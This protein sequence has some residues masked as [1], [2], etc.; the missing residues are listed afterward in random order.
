MSNEKTD[1]V[2]RFERMKDASGETLKKLGDA[3]Q[4]EEE[5]AAAMRGAAQSVEWKV[6]GHARLKAEADALREKAEA[7]AFGARF[8]RLVLAAMKRGSTNVVDMLGAAM[9]AAGVGSVNRYTG[10]VSGPCTVNCSDPRGIHAV[11]GVMGGTAN[12]HDLTGINTVVRGEPTVHEFRRGNATIRVKEPPDPVLCTCYQHSEP[13]IHVQAD[14]VPVEKW[15]AYAKELA[16]RAG[17]S[18]VVVDRADAMK[19]AKV[20]PGHEKSEPA[21]PAADPGADA[22]GWRNGQMDA[23]H[24][25]ARILKMPRPLP[26]GW[27]LSA[28]LSEVYKRLNDKPGPVV[29]AIRD[30]ALEEAARVCESRAK[31]NADIARRMSGALREAYD[32]FR[33]EDEAAAEEIRALKSKPAPQPS[34]NPGELP[35]AEPVHDFGWAL[36]QMRAGKKVRM[37]SWPHGYY[38]EM[39]NHLW[40]C[41]TGTRVNEWKGNSGHLLA[42]DWEVAE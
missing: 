34:G 25:L 24:H 40:W 30:A 3:I 35:K 41:I 21:P 13:H 18:R 19:D 5:A 7:E 42:T 4:A 10:V 17:V 23:A 28:A 33:K 22:T 36:Q 20:V 38:V 9:E 2:E 14:A 1:A 26:E 12:P 37:A 32:F 27:N 8:H 39:G 11:A 31:S 15:S 6:S 29:S 16:A